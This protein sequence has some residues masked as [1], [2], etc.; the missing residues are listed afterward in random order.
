MN[1]LSPTV[2]ASWLVIALSAV[3][4]PGGIA[5]G[6]ISVSPASDGD[7][8]VAAPPSPAAS[9]GQP[10][11]A[12][13]RA[14]LDNLDAVLLRLLAEQSRA[15][16]R[17]GEYRHRHGLPARDEAGEKLRLRKARD[18]AKPVGL[19]PE[20]VDNIFRTALEGALLRPGDR[21]PGTDR[22]SAP[23]PAPSELSD[24]Q[25]SL[26]NLDGA[27]VRLLAERFRTTEKVGVFK[28]RQGLP[29]RDEVREGAQLQRARLLANS[30]GLDPE[31]AQ[32]VFRLIFD[33]VVANHQRLQ[34]QSRDKGPASR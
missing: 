19:D 6:Q 8:S 31:V 20:V 1:C 24:L 18:Q 22:E 4:L 21:A 12:D 30:V 14:T 16:K 17:L 5:Q 28:S 34:E 32:R 10:S 3:T 11:L 33:A 23:K 15:A 27:L 25:A 26:E 29:A 9:D 13:F 2:R 7:R